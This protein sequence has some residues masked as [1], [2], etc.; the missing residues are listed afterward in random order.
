MPVRPAAP[1]STDPVHAGR[2]RGSAVTTPHLAGFHLAGAK[3]AGPQM[4]GAKMAGPQVAG[5]PRAGVRG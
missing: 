2:P 1:C 4:A 5:S 3:M